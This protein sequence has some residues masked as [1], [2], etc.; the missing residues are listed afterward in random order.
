MKKTVLPMICSFT[1]IMLFIIPVC[2]ESSFFVVDLV[3]YDDP[4]IPE[5]SCELLLF[6]DEDTEQNTPT[7]ETE[8]NTPFLISGNPNTLI[9][10]THS[11]EAYR[12]TSGYEYKE[13]S[14]WRTLDNSKSIVAVGNVLK[15]EMEKLGF[16]V[17]HDETDHEPPKLSTAYERSE[18]TMKK[19]LDENPGLSFFIDLHR[20]AADVET[21]SDD[22]VTIDG[23]ECAR[24]MFVVGKGEK[25][26]EKPDF[27]KHMQIV[28]LIMDE[29]EGI[30]PGFTRPIHE[31]TGRYN[32]HIGDVCLLI[33]VGHNANTL[34]QAMNSMP[35]LALAISKVISPESPYETVLRETLLAY[36]DQ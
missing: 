7:G 15:E 36:P 16:S 28:R 35:Y 8:T 29:L 17:I 19:Y 25:Y 9:Y 22:F 10:H 32:Q 11:H 6:P 13:S 24:I 5:S 18:I 14:D 1:I 27:D 31:K 34:E 33:E 21:K 20:D 2:A 12:M 3:P 26:D 23:R 4:P 30:C